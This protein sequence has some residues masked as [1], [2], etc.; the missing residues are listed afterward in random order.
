MSIKG[1]GVS[2][3]RRST[4]ATGLVAGFRFLSRCRSTRRGGEALLVGE[5]VRGEVFNGDGGEK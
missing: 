2:R 4:G 3:R 1:K 5:L